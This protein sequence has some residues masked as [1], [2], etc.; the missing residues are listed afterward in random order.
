[1]Q[2]YVIK[3]VMFFQVLLYANCRKMTSQLQEVLLL[4]IR[5]MGVLASLK[6]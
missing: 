3:S 2:H 1:M 4:L 6:P 5:G